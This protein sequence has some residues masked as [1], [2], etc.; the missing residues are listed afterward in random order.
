MSATILSPGQ[1][2]AAEALDEKIQAAI[3]ARAAYAQ[4]IAGPGGTLKRLGPG[5]WQSIPKPEP[6]PDGEA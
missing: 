2:A 4:E 1:A 5:L 3:A 6:K